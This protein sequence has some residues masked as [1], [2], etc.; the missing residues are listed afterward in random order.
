[1]V[2]RR[3]GLFFVLTVILAKLGNYKLNCIKI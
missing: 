2:V 1:M 3:D